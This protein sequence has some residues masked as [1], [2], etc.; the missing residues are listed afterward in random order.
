MVSVDGIAKSGVR[1][2]T[3]EIESICKDE[4]EAV[5]TFGVELI[6]LSREV[7]ETSAIMQN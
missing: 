6:H 2:I 3:E 4:D 1:K 7:A 5:Q